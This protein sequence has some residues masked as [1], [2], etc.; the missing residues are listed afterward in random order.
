MGLQVGAHGA[1]EVKGGARIPIGS[2][3][4]HNRKAFAAGQSHQI[5]GLSFL[6][7]SQKIGDLDGEKEGGRATDA[8]GFDCVGDST[9]GITAI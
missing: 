3:Q 6:G 5:S 7:R 2:R 4:Q 9:I 1:E 8:N